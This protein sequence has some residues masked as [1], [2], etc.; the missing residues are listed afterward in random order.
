MGIVAVIA[1]PDERWGERPVAMV[2]PTGAV[3]ADELREFLQP[4]VAAGIIVGYWIPDTFE[5][6]DDI[7]LTSTGKINKII[8]CKQFAK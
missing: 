7:P 2:K 1:R 3:T 8:L 6:V 5:F 4:K